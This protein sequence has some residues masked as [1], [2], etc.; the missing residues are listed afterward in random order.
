MLLGSKVTH[1]LVN[2]PD[3]AFEQFVADSK[4]SQAQKQE[5]LMSPKLDKDEYYRVA[6]IWIDLQDAA[7]A[8]SKLNNY[9]IEHRIFMEAALA[10]AFRSASADLA[11]VNNGL[12]NV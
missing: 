2:M 11:I 5:L 7:E 8:Q 3:R 12:S 10:E 9:V 6:M 4:L 1:N